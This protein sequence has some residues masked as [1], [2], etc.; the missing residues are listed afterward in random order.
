MS[1]YIM[2]NHSSNRDILKI[3][4]MS[5]TNI[6]HIISRYATSCGKN[7]TVFQF[8]DPDPRLMEKKFKETFSSQHAELEFYDSTSLFPYIRWCTDY[9]SSS[10]VIGDGK[11][12]CVGEPLTKAVSVQ[13]K[14]EEPLTKTVSVQC[15]VEEEKEQPNDSNVHRNDTHND[16]LKEGYN[17]HIVNT[18]CNTDLSSVELNAK[19]CIIDDLRV[20]CL[21][22]ETVLLKCKFSRHEK[23]CK[24]IPLDSCKYCFYRF[25][26]RQ[27]KSRHQKTCKKKS[28]EYK[29]V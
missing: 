16:S 7:I 27:S 6:K 20:K 12:K 19:W 26:S 15:E 21:S 3:G 1:F 24:G 9:T 18:N 22:C 23:S 10:P 25:S 11:L 5:T 4:F 2:Y 13:C 8:L 14:F 28:A 17:G 29:K